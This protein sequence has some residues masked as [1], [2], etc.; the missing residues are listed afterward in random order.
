VPTIGAFDAQNGRGEF[1]DIE[2][3]NGR[4]I[5][6]RNVWSDITANSCRFEQSSSVDGGKTWEINW[7][8]TDTRMKGADESEKASSL[9]R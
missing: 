6:V 5:F 7:I 8:T 3:Y 1:F 4:T 9:S 2:P